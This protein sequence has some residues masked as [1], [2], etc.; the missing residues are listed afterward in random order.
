MVTIYKLDVE[1]AG[2]QEK[3]LKSCVLKFII[4]GV[5]DFQFLYF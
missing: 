3:I 5:I 1:K 4:L 2:R